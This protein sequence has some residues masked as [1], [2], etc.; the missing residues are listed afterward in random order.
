MAKAVNPFSTWPY[1][2]E[3]D[4]EAFAKDETFQPT[5]FRLGPLTARQDQLIKDHAVDLND[6]ED[7]PRAG[8]KQ[9]SIIHE[10]VRYGVKGWDH[11]LDDEDNFIEAEFRDAKQGGGLTNGSMDRIVPYITELCEAIRERNKVTLDD[12]KNLHSPS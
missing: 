4:R 1:I 5:V 2:L 11:L 6:L 8:V 12:L 7:A 9:G 3:E 10:T